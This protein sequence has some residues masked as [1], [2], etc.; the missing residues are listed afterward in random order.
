MAGPAPAGVVAAGPARPRPAGPVSAGRPRPVAA[1]W[2]AR[3]RRHGP[4]AWPVR[5]AARRCS[6]AGRGAWRPPARDARR[7][8]PGSHPGPAR[9]RARNV[10]NRHSGW[11]P[12]SAGNCLPPQR[13]G[14]RRT[15]PGPGPPARCAIPARPRPRAAA[16]ARRPPRCPGRAGRAR[17]GTTNKRRRPG[18]VG[19]TPRADPHRNGNRGRRPVL[20]TYV[21]ILPS[22]RQPGPGLALAPFRGLRYAQDRVSGLAEVTSPPYDV[23]AHEAEDHLRASDPH[24]VVRLILPRPDRGNPDAAYADAARTLR[25]WRDDGILVADSRPALYV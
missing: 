2:A 5:R 22:G 6:A 14:Q 3:G 8:P 21:Q 15:A 10:R 12:R 20:L 7:R 23:I 18:P 17:G 4:G 9:G 13:T 19:W 24:N 16:A 11:P 25:G 1:G